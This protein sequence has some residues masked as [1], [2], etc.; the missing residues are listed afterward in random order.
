VPVTRIDSLPEI[1]LVGRLS[2]GSMPLAEA[3]E[4][5]GLEVVSVPPEEVLEVIARDRPDLVIFA[6]EVAPILEPVAARLTAPRRGTCLLIAGGSG[7]PVLPGV[8][9]LLLAGTGDELVAELGERWRAHLARRVVGLEG[10]VEALDAAR[11]EDAERFEAFVRVVSHDLRAPL[12]RIAAFSE[13]LEE[14]CV[15]VVDD[16]AR[17]YL[18][19]IFQGAVEGQHLVGALVNYAR[20][21][22]RPLEIEQLELAEVARTASLRV[23]RLRQETGGV[24]RVADDLPPVLADAVQLEEVLVRLLENALLFADPERPA[25][26]E[27]DASAGDGEVLISIADNGRGVEPEHLDRVFGILEQLHGKAVHDGFGLGL[28]VCRRLVELHG[29]RIWLTSTPGL[30][31]TAHI[32]LPERPDVLGAWLD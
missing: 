11:R 6:P 3:L 26:I 7:G 31:T 8:R 27:L 14:K 15:D 1:L 22:S 18:T 9:R 30:G 17:E 32:S 13:R 5:R 12:R 10:E 16:R 20:L 2:L 19:R 23:E 24:L 29:G 28:P 25:R 4:S 21:G